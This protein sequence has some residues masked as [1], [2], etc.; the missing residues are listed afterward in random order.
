MLLPMVMMRM[1]GGQMISTTMG[2]HGKNIGKVNSGSN[3]GKLMG[4]RKDLEPSGNRLMQS[5]GKMSIVAGNSNRDN[6]TG[7][8]M[9][10]AQNI[11]NMRHR[12]GTNGTINA[13]GRM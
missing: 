1:T 4:N 5:M 9:A 13:M 7:T 3:M 8:I 6:E 10:G 2:T 11:V 12:N